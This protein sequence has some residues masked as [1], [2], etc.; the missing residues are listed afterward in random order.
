MK[1]DRTFKHIVESTLD[2]EVVVTQTSQFAFL[3][4]GTNPKN[5]IMNYT[6]LNFIINLMVN[7]IGVYF[8]SEKV[9][10]IP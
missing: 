7:P 3:V 10:K 9:T 2:S 8:L 1:V 5:A 6:Y 4:F